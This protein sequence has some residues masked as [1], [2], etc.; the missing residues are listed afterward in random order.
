[1]IGLLLTA[2]DNTGGGSITPPPPTARTEMSVVFVDVG[3]GDSI[4]IRAPNG[5]VMLIDGGRSISLANNLIIPQIKAWGASQVDVLV[6]T[7]PDADHIGGLVGVL[8]SFPVKLAAL[9]GD[10]HATQIYERLLTNI[11]DKNIAAL[12]VRTGT[13]IPF[14]S[15]VKLEVL[16]PDD[17]LVNQDNTNDGSIVI[18]LTYGQ[19]SFLFTGDA[20]FAENQS[21]LRNNLDVRATVLKLGHHGSRTSTDEN[22]LRAVQPQL[23]I[24]SAGAGNPF[25][26]P[27]AEV[28]A[29]LNNLGIQY[30]RTDEHGTITITSDGTQLRVTSQR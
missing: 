29:A 3:Q 11:R 14:D 6:V 21:I 8:E 10:Q 24:V 4:L 20:E 27:H 16:G 23:G 17:A 9:T 13:I 2:C 26:H 15:A 28:V 18:K 30:I 1:L 19:T 7:H 22:W 5:Q 12:Q 25:G